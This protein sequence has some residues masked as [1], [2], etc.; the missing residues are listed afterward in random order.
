MPKQNQI[1]KQKYIKYKNKYLSLQQLGSGFETAEKSFYAKIIKNENAYNIINNDTILKKFGELPSYDT[2]KK[3]PIEEYPI[4]KKIFDNIKTKSNKDNID[5]FI[6]LYLNNDSDINTFTSAF[7]SAIEKFDYLKNKKKNDNIIK[8]SFTSLIE[9]NQYIESKTTDLEDYYW[10]KEIEEKGKDQVIIVFKSDKVTIYNP[11][12]INGSCY[13]GKKTNW[14]T[15]AKDDNKFDDYNEWGPLYIIQSNKKPKDKYQLHLNPF[16]LK[17]HNQTDITIEN[18]KNHF[19]DTELNS[20]L[21]CLQ[22]KK[23]NTE[24]SILSTT[25][26]SINTE[27]PIID[28]DDTEIFNY[29]VDMYKDNNNINNC[30][31]LCNDFS[32]IKRLPKL[33]N[34]N[35][36]IENKSIETIDLSP[37]SNIK[38]IGSNFLRGCSNLETIDL[39]PLSNVTLIGNGFLQACKRL[40]NIN[41]SLLSNIIS[42]GS[43]FLCECSNLKTIDLSPLSKITKISNRFL[44]GCSNL[45]TIDL[46]PLSKI[47]SIGSEFLGNCSNL[48]TIDLSQLSKITSIGDYFLRGCS[49]LKTIELSPLSNVTSIGNYFLS[50]CSNLKTI[51]LSPLSNVTLIGNGFLQTCKRLININLS[52]LSKI[53]SIG[54]EF[55]RGCSNL[56]TIDLSPLSKITSISHD[57]L[58]GCS[59]L[60]TIDLS[61]LSNITSIDLFFLHGC[62]NLKTIDLSPLSKLKEI[63]GDFFLS[64][65]HKD[66]IIT[67][68]L[69]QKEIINEK[70]LYKHTFNI[71]N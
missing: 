55:L 19:N 14:C 62:S 58:S 36:D 25:T 1:Y 31:Y 51:E 4:F 27:L 10:Q 11:T 17:D 46:S 52:P 63:N 23:I 48:E 66:L 42:I 9:L 28:V 65:T 57:F 34:L 5:L 12:D 30:I 41:L 6:T 47:T 70:T 21:Y 60:K 61:P 59:N 54:W 22:I 8:N 56:E 26:R 15:A 64:N 33:S 29:F 49:N 18:L 68:T 3:T 16:E 35:I 44:D 20:F 50:G 40:I 37:L 71:V 43:Q 7:N 2:I 39:S 13:Y 38:S 53:T 45:K 69:K 67:C 24:F 32:F